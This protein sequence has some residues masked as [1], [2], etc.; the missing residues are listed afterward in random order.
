MDNDDAVLATTGVT[1]CVYA[2]DPRANPIGHVA[3]FDHDDR[4]TGGDA[5]RLFRAEGIAGPTAVFR[6]SRG[7]YHCWNL[8]VRGVDRTAGVLMAGDDD[9]KHVVVGENRGHWRLRTGPK[10]RQNNDCYKPAPTLV[11]QFAVIDGD[12]FPA[13]S[14]P[15]LQLIEKLF[16]DLA[17]ELFVAVERYVEHYRNAHRPSEPAY[18]GRTLE[19]KQY[20]TFTD[21]G[22]ELQRV[23]STGQT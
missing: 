13:V 6:S 4:V 20:A 18:V 5:E 3:L 22:K 11:D 21:R 8:G 7:K 1:S 19:L 14:L 10:R 15:H 9:E 12:G 16:P 2:D 17:D 23:S